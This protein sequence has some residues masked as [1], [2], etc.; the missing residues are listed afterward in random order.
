MEAFA[1]TVG[2]RAVGLRPGVLD[3]INRQKQLIVVPLWTTAELNTAI[4]QYADQVDAIVFQHWQNTVVE[5]IRSRDRRLGGMPLAGCDLRVSV[6]KRL[7]VDTV[8]TLD[9]ADIVRVL[10]SQV[11]WV[12]DL[13]LAVNLVCGTLPLHRDN[14]RVGQ[15]YSFLGDFGRQHFEPELAALQCV[16]KPDAA[17]PAGRYKHAC[18]PQLV[19]DADLIGFE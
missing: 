8:N 5:K 12:L 13:Y 4:R 6:D 17:K 2:L 14:L 19:A 18:F 11:A 7:L 10:R 9:R 16:A 15:Q 1:D 3:V